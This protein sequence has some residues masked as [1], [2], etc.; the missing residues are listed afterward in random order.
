MQLVGELCSSYDSLDGI[1]VGFKQHQR[2]P[3][4]VFFRRLI[5]RAGGPYICTSRRLIVG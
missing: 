5:S 1:P 2:Q 3:A 4:D